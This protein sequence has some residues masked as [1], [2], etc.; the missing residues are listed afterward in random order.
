MDKGI[1]T[2]NPFYSTTLNNYQ[3][4]RIHLYNAQK[5]GILRKSSPRKKVSPKEESGQSKNGDSGLPVK[6]KDVA[7]PIQMVN[8]SSEIEVDNMPRQLPLI[9]ET[10]NKSENGA[11]EDND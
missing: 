9:P 3:G 8:P 4:V 6:N 10:N 7:D 11:T 2:T 1:K 5:F